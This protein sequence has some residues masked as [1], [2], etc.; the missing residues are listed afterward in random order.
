MATTMVR[1]SSSMGLITMV[2]MLTTKVGRSHF[3][4][5]SILVVIMIS[6]MVGKSSASMGAI[7][8]VRFEEKPDSIYRAVSLRRYV[9]TH[10][11][12]PQS[13]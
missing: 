2:T 12:K 6:T 7:R 1:R 3:S 10:I 9:P 11:S 8:K 5:W 4:M 13:L